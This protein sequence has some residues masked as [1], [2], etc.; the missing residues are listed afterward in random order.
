MP[1]GEIQLLG[2]LVRMFTTLW[3]H[4]HSSYAPYIPAN[5][6]CWYFPD[7]VLYFLPW[8]LSSHYSSHFISHWPTPDSSYFWPLLWHLPWVSPSQAGLIA[9]SFFIHETFA[10]VLLRHLLHCVLLLCACLSLPP[11]F[12]LLDKGPS[13]THL[14]HPLAQCLVRNSRHAVSVPWLVDN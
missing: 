7:Y 11:Y 2:S 10:G 9:T 14:L 8:C 3:I 12:E 5:S 1:I 6:N 4:N 13:L